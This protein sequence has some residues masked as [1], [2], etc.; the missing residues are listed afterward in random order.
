M[1]TQKIPSPCT[2]VIDAH[3]YDGGVWSQSY[4]ESGFDHNPKIDVTLPLVKSPTAAQRSSW[5]LAS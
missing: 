1:R 2:T 5:R 3:R 4:F